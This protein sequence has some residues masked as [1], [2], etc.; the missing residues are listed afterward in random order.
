MIRQI[1]TRIQSRSTI[2]RANALGR[3]GRLLLVAAGALFNSQAIAYPQQG[4]ESNLAAGRQ[5]DLPVGMTV[6]NVTAE[7]VNSGD[8]HPDDVHWRRQADRVSKGGNVTSAF[9]MDAHAWTHPWSADVDGDGFCGNGHFGTPKPASSESKSGAVWRY[10]LGSSEMIHLKGNCRAPRARV[11]LWEY[12]ATARG[13]VSTELITN[14]SGQASVSVEQALEASSEGSLITV[15]SMSLSG[16]YYGAGGQLGPSIP[17]TWNTP[18]D[19]NVRYTS[20]APG[21]ARPLQAA[22]EASA[23][24]VWALSAAECDLSV[25]SVG[26]VPG[27]FPRAWIDQWARSSWHISFDANDGQQHLGPE[28]P[29]TYDVTSEEEL[30]HLASEH[31]ILVFH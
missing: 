14:L 13:L 23:L 29:A 27:T 2:V 21:T 12:E 5:G 18:W 17:L 19:S 7:K 30:G 22:G 9:K 16:S 6:V 10:L 3:T 8:L 26:L 20:S 11:T 1:K 25:D 28:N 15:G 4:A 31:G 24:E